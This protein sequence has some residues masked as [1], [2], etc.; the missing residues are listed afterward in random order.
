MSRTIFA[1]SQRNGSATLRRRP[2]VGYVID[3]SRSACLRRRCWTRGRT[4]FSTADVTYGYGGPG[5]ARQMIH[6]DDSNIMYS[7]SIIIKQYDILVLR[8]FFS[9]YFF[10]FYFFFIPTVSARRS[11]L[12]RPRY[13]DTTPAGDPYRLTL[14]LVIFAIFR[15]RAYSP[16][17]PRTIS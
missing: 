14:K 9:F 3:S 7:E 12:K 1:V 10:S 4:D 17:P 8:Y 11:R 16:P 15:A 2:S 13:D 5:P 6:R